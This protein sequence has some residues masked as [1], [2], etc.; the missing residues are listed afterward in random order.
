MTHSKLEKPKQ[1][2]KEE[3]EERFFDGRHLGTAR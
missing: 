1:G 3:E 2:K